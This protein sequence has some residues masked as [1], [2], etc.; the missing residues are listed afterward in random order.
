MAQE[1]GIAEPWAAGAGRGHWAELRRDT[2]C[3]EGQ[4][5][6]SELSGVLS[7]YDDW[8]MYNTFATQVF[9]S[10]WETANLLCARKLLLLPKKE[11]RGSLCEESEK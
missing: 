7:G 5:K 3:L 2:D 11:G 6:L 4:T 9:S 10:H 8:V 1:Q